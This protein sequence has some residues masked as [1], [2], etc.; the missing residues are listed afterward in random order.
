MHN[1]CLTSALLP[2]LLYF[3][4]SLVPY[5][6]WNVVGC[7]YQRDLKSNAFN[8]FIFS[9]CILHSL[10]IR[11]NF[12]L[13]SRPA[14]P[15]WLESAPAPICSSPLA[16]TCK[17]PLA[18]GCSSALAQTGTSSPASAQ[19]CSGKIAWAPA[20]KKTFWE[21]SDRSSS[22]LPASRIRARRPSC[23]SRHN[24]PMN[25]PDNWGLRGKR[26]KIIRP[27]FFTFSYVVEH[28]FS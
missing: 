18:R 24:L 17:T 2:S 23:G 26:A 22:A 16:Q 8:K 11:G 3:D 20:C 6:S 21:Q 27:I 4:Y 19:V 13:Q 28:D 1:K 10:R 7:I 25:K 5:T 15:P 9:P 14:W 12:H